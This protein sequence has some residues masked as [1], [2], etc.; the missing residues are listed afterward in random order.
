MQNPNRIVAQRLLQQIYKESN[1]K[2][3]QANNIFFG[4]S[5]FMGFQSNSS[6]TQ[7]STGYGIKCLNALPKGN[8]IEKS[9]DKVKVGSHCDEQ[10]ELSDYYGLTVNQVNLSLVNGQSFYDK[11]PVQ[12]R[13]LFKIIK[14]KTTGETRFYTI[15]DGCWRLNNPYKD[16]W[17]KDEEYYGKGYTIDFVGQLPEANQTIPNLG[18]EI[19]KLPITVNISNVQLLVA[20][21]NVS[22]TGQ[23]SSGI[24]V[25]NT[26]AIVPIGS[27]ITGTHTLTF[28]DYNNNLTGYHSTPNIKSDNPSQIYDFKGSEFTFIV[29]RNSLYLCSGQEYYKGSHGFGTILRFN[30]LTGWNSVLTGKSGFF[31]DDIRYLNNSATDYSTGKTIDPD[32]RSYDSATDFNPRFIA[33]FKNRAYIAGTDANPLQIKQSERNNIENFVDNALGIQTPKLTT[34]DGDRPSSLMIDTGYNKITTLTV[35]NDKL[36]IGTNKGWWLYTPEN[37]SLPDGQ[38]FTAYSIQENNYTGAGPIRPYSTLNFRNR[39]YYVGNYQVVPEIA[40]FESQSRSGNG[41]A[42]GVYNKVSEPIDSFMS[43]LDFSESC[44]GQFQEHTLV[45]CREEKC[46]NK[47]KNY[48]IVFN[49][50]QNQNGSIPSFSVLDYI[51][52]NYFFTTKDGCYFTNNDD[53]DVYKIIPNYYTNEDGLKYTAEYQSGWTGFN[54]KSDTA[55]SVKRLDRVKISGYFTKGSKLILKIYPKMTKKKDD[56]I[57]QSVSEP[58]TFSYDFSVDDKDDNTLFDNIETRYGA[59]Y[60]D[61]LLTFPKISDSVIT[62]E[63]LSYEFQIQNS[64]FWHIESITFDGEKTIDLNKNTISN[65]VSVQNNSTL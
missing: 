47:G 50:F 16:L 62:Y 36:Y 44:I 52:P 56:V 61:V 53:G 9:F 63:V 65:L 46:N 60:Y 30:R 1:D 59:S 15:K 38:P 4:D 14:N 27:L 51:N 58:H 12:D 64:N 8:G 39:L 13:D 11:Q 18:I 22:I 42:I 57:F 23:I 19:T 20:N 24:F 33:L 48:C 49:E 6:P 35:Y 41:Q 34:A 17:I 43:K 25:P 45:S 29:W 26:G 3:K 28:K 40:Y 10:I 54:P 32:Y 31:E 2:A 55:L 7:I 5:S 37:I 21:T